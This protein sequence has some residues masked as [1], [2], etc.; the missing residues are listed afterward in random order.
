MSDLE[1][2]Q[3]QMGNG[4]GFIAALDQ[5]GGS[6]PK[7]LALYGVNADDYESEAAMFAE[8][9]KM[10]ERIILAPNFTKDKVIGAILFERTLGES[11]NGKP[12][13]EFLWREK[14]IVPFL[15]IDKGL[16]DQAN[17]VQLMKPM[18]GLD[19]VLKKAAG[20]GIF[21]TKERSVIHEADEGGIRAVVAQ[22]F[23]VAR[24]VSAAGL[25]PI[26]EPEV[27]INSSTK[28]E[29]EGMMRDAISEELSKL[30]SDQNVMLKLTLPS[31]ANFFDP[32]ADH[33]RVLRV[34]ALSGGYSTD[35]ACKLLAEN[36]KMI[37]SFS[38]ALT[39]GLKKQMSDTDFATAIGANIDQIHR[40]S[41]A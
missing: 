31:A 7:A 17:G 38:R 33:D 27:N 1:T 39:E 30:R 18:S 20:M 24:Q 10:R 34:V 29:A 26:I 23:D 13:A 32:L 12:V 36:K 16:E 28:A 15:K 3:A 8:M 2:M 9:Q 37:A 19:D 4:A 25:V 21:G 40:A 41:V 14:Q 22:Q 5:S 6:T 11:I 35:E